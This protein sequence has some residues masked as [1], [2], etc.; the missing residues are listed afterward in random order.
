MKRKVLLLAILFGVVFTSVFAAR[1]YK[2]VVEQRDKAQADVI[3]LGEQ[4][5]QDLQ[6][7]EEK[8]GEIEAKVAE[9]QGQL[10]AKIYELDVMRSAVICSHT[11][12][13]ITDPNIWYEDVSYLLAP[14]L[15]TMGFSLWVTQLTP[16]DAGW[17][18]DLP[19]L[20]LLDTPAGWGRLIF[21]IENACI[22]L[23]TSITN[24]NP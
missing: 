6:L 14:Y 22:I 13:E 1:E 4:Y 23:E 17:Q 16:P 10:D 12:E 7:K 8:L 21:D 11:W 5:Q 18:D 15:R 20:L 2:K 24:P 3:E 9:L 19:V